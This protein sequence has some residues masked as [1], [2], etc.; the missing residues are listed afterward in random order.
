MIGALQLDDL[1]NWTAQTKCKMQTPSALLTLRHYTVW[2]ALALV[3]ALQ[4]RPDYTLD[5]QLHLLPRRQDG[6]EM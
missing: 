5:I 2:L 4:T 6:R 1:K 3:S